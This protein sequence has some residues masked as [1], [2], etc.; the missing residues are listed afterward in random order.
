MHGLL[1]SRVRGQGYDGASNMRGAISG[2]RTLIQEESP[3]AYYVHCFA[4]RLQLALMS[5]AKNN[6]RVS[7]FFSDLYSICVVVGSSCKRADQL[8]QLQAEQIRDAISSGDLVTGR[9]LNQEQ[10]VRR[11]AETRWSSHYVS[12][13]R[14]LELFDSILKLLETIME[15]GAVADSRGEA[16]RLFEVASSFDFVFML[17]LFKSILLK[18]TDL[19]NML[20]RK[21]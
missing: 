4:H 7:R 17:H 20:Q 21:E 8:P 14:V 15:E 18:T 3:S 9:G 1:L 2:L 12:L 13:C 11:P 6:L 5:A 16:S 10:S 19:S